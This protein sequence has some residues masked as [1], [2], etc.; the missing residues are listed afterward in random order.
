MHGKLTVRNCHPQEPRDAAAYERLKEGA[1]FA[2]LLSRP[3]YR[4]NENLFFAEADGVI[5]GYVNVLPERGIGRVILEYG[6]SSSDRLETVLGEL[7][8]CALKRAKELGARVAHLSIP[9]AEAAQAEALSNLEFKAVRRFYELGLDVSSVNLEAVDQRDLVYRYLK[10]GEDDLL[11]R[12]ENRCF[13]GTW[14]FN[15][16]TAEYIGWEL[17][18]RG[19]CP[20][21]VILALSEGKPIGYCWTEAQCGRDSSTGRSKGRI[22]MLGVDPSYREKGIGRGLLEAGLL[23]LKNKGREIID[24]TVDSQNVAAVTLYRSLGFQPYGETVWYEKAV[25]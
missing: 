7:L 25:H 16:N 24:I 14:G 1:V 12:I 23:H 10:A 2:H 11:A 13:S 5:V 21:D 22:Y 9:S 20:D 3:G 15:P 6:A 17:S 18:T 19:D 8:K 4:V